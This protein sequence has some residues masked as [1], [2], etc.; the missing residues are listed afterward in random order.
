M[1]SGSSVTKQIDEEFSKA[2]AWSLVLKLNE[3]KNIEATRVIE[4]GV[5][6]RK[7]WKGLFQDTNVGARGM[8]LSYVTPVLQDVKP[9]VQLSEEDVKVGNE[10]WSNA[11][12]LYVIGNTP[13]IRAIMRI[14]ATEWNF[15]TKHK[16][17]L[18]DDGFFVVKMNNTADKN[19]RNIWSIHF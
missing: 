6:G 17:Y 9:I 3:T 4:K 12:I 1:G 7:T 16:V 14:I 5:P 18:H 2:G 15:V 10:V 8:E 13:S 19:Y 11:I